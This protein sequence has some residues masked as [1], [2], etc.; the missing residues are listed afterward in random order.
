MSRKETYMQKRINRA[1]EYYKK[2]YWR[3]GLMRFDYGKGVG[4]EDTP[5][6]REALTGNISNIVGNSSF[7]PR[8]RRALVYNPGHTYGWGIPHSAYF[9][10]SIHPYLHDGINETI[11]PE[12]IIEVT[13]TRDQLNNDG[14]TKVITDFLHLTNAE[15]LEKFVKDK[16]KFSAKSLQIM[17]EVDRKN[18]TIAA[19]E[20]AV[21]EY[22]S[23]F[24]L[25]PKNPT[26][27]QKVDDMVIC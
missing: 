13:L 4:T 22:M 20:N 15:V 16:S 23:D 25:L 27:E 10:L 8:I 6:Y 26:Y 12:D 24:E 1:L 19:I 17:E 21:D 3:N 14:I 11:M 18:K 2:A 9:V 7:S 5:N